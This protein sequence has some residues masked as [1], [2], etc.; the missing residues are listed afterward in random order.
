MVTSNNTYRNLLLAQLPAEARERLQP[1]LE[2]VPLKFKQ[3][4]DE[5]DQQ[6]A[7]IYFPQTAVCSIVTELPDG[8]AVE[9][10]TVGYEGVTGVPSALTGARFPALMI[11]QIAGSAFK[12]SVRTLARELGIPNSALIH[13]I[14][15][16]LNFA[17]AM[18]AQGSACNRA[19]SVDARLARW[20]LMTHDRVSTDEFSLT[21]EFLAHMLGVQRPTVNIA[22]ATLQ[23]AGFIDYTRGRIVVL[24]RP[25]LESAA[26]ACY[27]FILEHLKDLAGQQRRSANTA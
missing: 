20:L 5:Q 17:V 15:K 19:H 18:L 22:A 2:E 10:G 9:T 21:Q 1:D 11:C 3:T 16:Y 24:D 6:V 23:R 26:C 13:V 27:A 8:T 4:I 12:L 25:G 14:H 7:A